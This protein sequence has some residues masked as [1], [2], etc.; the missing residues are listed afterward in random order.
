MEKKLYQ[1]PQLET[2]EIAVE[3]GIAQSPN[4]GQPGRPGDIIY[5]PTYDYEI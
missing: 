2:V 5:D 4:F 3:K 1:A